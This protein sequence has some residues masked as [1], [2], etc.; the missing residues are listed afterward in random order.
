[1]AAILAA[2]VV[3]FT[4]LIAEDE[5]GTLRQLAECRH[6][7]NGFVA[8]HGGRIFNTAGDSIMCAFDT[9]L[10][11][12]RA[13]I[14]IQDFAQAQID[15][16]TSGQWLPFRIGISVGEVVERRNDLL[17]MAVNLAARLQTLALPGGICI[18]RAVHEAVSAQI[19]ASFVD[20]GERRVKNIP[21]PVHA[22]TIA[23]PRRPKERMPHRPRLSFTVRFM[24]LAG[25]CLAILFGVGGLVSDR[26]VSRDPSPERLAD[27]SALPPADTTAQALQLTANPVESFAKFAQKGGQIDDPG[28]A[29]G[30]YH[31]ALLFEAKGEAIAAHRVYYTLARMGL[32]FIDPHL[33][34]AALVQA[35]E[36]SF[37]ARQVYAELNEDAPTRATALVYALQFDGAERRERLGNL[38]TQHPDFAPAQYF[39]AEEY[40]ESRISPLQA[41][42]DRQIEY[43]AL[44]AFLDAHRDD[45][46]A[47]FFLDQ[48]VLN[49]W[50][51]RAQRRH[52]QIAASAKGAD[53]IPRTAGEP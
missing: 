31:N 7:F 25:V 11:A 2:D 19:S 39:L 53:A 30:L 22:F 27:T 28:S 38:F 46:L 24:S 17:G 34:Y 21:F 14:E 50:L 18:S 20:L 3:G 9:A 13:A 44:T 37:I 6:V 32:D 12:T 26:Q 29:P 15:A 1:M 5:E 10:D 49:G 42:K 51:D 48:S 23:G 43:K 33:R 4:R 35:H 36:G 45:R 41:A 52:D 16:L 47:P 40:S 8:R